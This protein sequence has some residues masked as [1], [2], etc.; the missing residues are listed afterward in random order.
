MNS[1]P[2]RRLPPLNALRAFE[3]SGR[4]LNFRL[5]SEEL[6]VTQGAVAQ[7]V[8]LLEDVLQVSLFNR[9]PRGLAFTAE[10]HGYFTAVQR[11][12]TIV[13]EATE[14]LNR[15][16]TSVTI[17]TTPSFASRWLIP[18]LAEFTEMHPHIDVR[19]I[20][21][22]AICNFRSEG[23]DIAIRLGKAPFAKGLVSDLLFPV[24]VFPVASPYL[25]ESG[26]SINTLS[27]LSKCVLLH[28]HH[29]LWPEFFSALDHMDRFDTLRGPRFSQTSLAIDAAIA[30][31]GVALISEAVVERDIAAGRLR[32]LFNLSLPLSLGYHVVLPQASARSEASQKMRDW[33]LAQFESARSG[34]PGA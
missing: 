31:Q 17:S 18:R 24:H 2:S 9:L 11:A 6:G 13:L 4:H 27:D 32:R 21:D 12:L 19:V 10:G 14:A 28:D 5:A 34:S 15:R 22:I 29:D 33:L 30:G 20:A 1:F 23:V 16:S 25:L 8:R 7:Q 3:A 26:Q